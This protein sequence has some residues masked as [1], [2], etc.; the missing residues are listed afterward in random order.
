[1]TFG[2]TEFVLVSVLIF[3]LFFGYW[4]THESKK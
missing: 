2:A 4:V 3:L 1:M